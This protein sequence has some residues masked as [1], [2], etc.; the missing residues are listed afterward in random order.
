MIEYFS[1]N[2]ALF[3]YHHTQHCTFNVSQQ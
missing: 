2:Y 3:R 1:L